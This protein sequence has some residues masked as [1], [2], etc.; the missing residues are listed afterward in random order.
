MI[1]YRKVIQHTLADDHKAVQSSDS[2]NSDVM[3]A[4]DT[5]IWHHKAVALHEVNG[6]MWFHCDD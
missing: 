4:W 2:F 5:F 6:E 3:L 1:D